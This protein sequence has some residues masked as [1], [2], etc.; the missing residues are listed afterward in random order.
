MNSKNSRKL[1]IITGSMGQGGLEKITALISNYYSIRGWQVKIL[2][3]FQDNVG[4]KWNLEKNVQIVP[5]IARYSAIKHRIKSIPKWLVF[6][7]KTVNA[8]SPNSILCMT[9]RIGTL[10]ACACPKY[11]RKIVV[12]EI[13]DPH[14]PKRSL[15][16]NKLMEFLL[17]GIKGYIFQTEWEKSC[18]GKRAQRKSVIIPN[19]CN[20]NLDPSFT[21]DSRIVSTSRLDN[22]Q[23]RFDISLTIFDCLAKKY[24]KITYEIYGGG[25]DE[26][27]I[28]K[29]ASKLKSKDRIH[30]HGPTSNVINLIQ[31]ARCFLM[32]S[33]FEGLSNSLL[34]ANLSGIPCVTSD[35]PGF[36][37]IIK[38]GVNGFVYKRQNVSEAVTKI[39][40][41]LNNDDLCNRFAKN[42]IKQREKF[43][44]ETNLQKYA[45]YIGIDVT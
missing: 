5:F 1:A 34:E 32:T 6:I 18:Y 37:A 2:T 26:E 33:D 17:R 38:D 4:T 39:E 10:T 20:V 21:Y 22:T 42:S 28:K 9:P 41:L 36:N 27:Y 19:P 24:P 8:F 40:L 3:L 43:N 25:D 14:S 44:S 7:N 31:G 29:F 11:K 15:F 23:K 35:W 30:F 45:E 13:N 12:R 16:Q